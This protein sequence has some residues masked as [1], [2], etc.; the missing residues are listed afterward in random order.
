MRTSMRGYIVLLRPLNCCIAAAAILVGA[1]VA[2]GFAGLGGSAIQVAVATV[3]G[4]LFT[5]A[6]NALNDY[7]DRE[8]DKM[9]HPARPIPSGRVSAPEALRFA[10]ILFVTAL[11]LSILAGWLALLIV[12]IDL[13]AM[14]SYEVRFKR[15]GSSG[16]VIIGWLV[17]SLFIFGGA[18]AYNGYMQALSRVSWMGLLAFLATLGREIVKDIEDVAGDVDRRTLPMVIGVDK[19]GF[20]AS[21]AFVFGVAL[22][23][24]PFITNVLGAAYL[25]VVTLADGIFIY[26]AWISTANPTLASRA[27]KY[28]MVVALFAF[29]VGG[30]L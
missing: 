27:A 3:V 13:A 22:S 15:K 26:C 14:V 19:A 4:V 7:Y 16:N 24:F 25:A 8:V 23:P 10:A 12:V 29:L 21:A 11:A 17:A 28:G 1:I 6:G 5:G 30:A 2:V 20:M 9:N 18:A